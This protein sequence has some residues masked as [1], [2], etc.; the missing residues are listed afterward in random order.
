MVNPKIR[1]NVSI[2]SEATGAS[3]TPEKRIPRNKKNI[4]S[5][6]M[7]PQRKDTFPNQDIYMLGTRKYQI[8][9]PQL[10]KFCRGYK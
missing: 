7:S 10:A 9:P 5:L 2:F 6:T 8:L 4:K 3:E 1:T